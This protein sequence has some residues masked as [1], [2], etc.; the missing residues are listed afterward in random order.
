MGEAPDFR[1]ETQI[2]ST[3]MNTNLLIVLN[4]RLNAV[5][6]EMENAWADYKDHRGD[7]SKLRRYTAALR[8]ANRLHQTIKALA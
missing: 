3:G 6:V 8:R 5:F 2:E 1:T 7:D 4:R